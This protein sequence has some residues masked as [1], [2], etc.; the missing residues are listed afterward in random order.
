VRKQQLLIMK[1]FLLPLLAVSAYGGHAFLEDGKEYVYEAE[2]YQNA[3]TMDYSPSAAA[4]GWRFRVRMQVAG[5]KINFRVTDRSSSQYV[6]P[7]STTD[8]AW[9]KTTFTSGPSSGSNEFS[10]TYKNGQAVSIDVP[11]SFETHHRN[12]AR[13][14]ATSW[15][16]SLENKDYFLTQENLL[17]GDCKVQY[18]VSNNVI[19]KSVS[20]FRDCKHRKF[21]IVDNFRGYRCDGDWSME[22]WDYYGKENEGR[23]DPEP[24][25]SSTNTM[26]VVEKKGNRFQVNKMVVSGSVAAQYFESK[27]AS[28]FI[29]VNKTLTLADIR[30]SDGSIRPS[31]TIT[32]EDL[33]YEMSDDDYKWNKDR[34]LKAKE[35]F[36]SS[37]EYFKED[38]VTLQ[39]GIVKILDMI[40]ENFDIHDV[41]QPNMDKMHKFGAG[42]AMPILYAMNYNSL[43]DVF[44]Q[45]K[46]DTSE[47]GVAKQNM[48]REFVAEAGTSAA[49][50]FIKDAVMTNL[51]D[52]SSDAARAVTGI[53]FHIRRPN[54][55]LVNA[56]AEILESDRLGLVK[57]AGPLALAHLIQRT[58]Y[59]AGNPMSEDRRQCVRELSDTWAEKY[60][61]KFTETEDIQ[62][63]LM[64]ISFLTNLRSVKAKELLK[65][66][67]YG[68]YPGINDQIQSKAVKAAFWGT[69][70]TQSTIEFY[71][72]IFM[73]MQNGHGSR[74]AAI[75]QMFIMNSVDVTTLS[76]IMTQMFAEQDNE[77]LNYVF[78]LFEKYANSKYGCSEELK[79]DKVKYFLK[80]MRQM[81]IH[82]TEFGFGISKTYRMSFVQ[83]KYGYGGGYEFWVLGSHSSTTPLELGMRLDT[84]LFGGYQSNLL[85][86][87]IRIEGL[88][89]TLIRKFFMKMPENEWRI[90][91]L[92]NVFNSMNVALKPDQ[93][94]KVEFQVLL[95]DVVVLHKMFDEKAAEKGGELKEFMSSL[96]GTGNQYS[97]NHQRVLQWGSAIY[98]QPTESGLPM[99]YASALTS[100]V[101]LEATV[102][103]GLSR[104][105]I[106]RDIDYDLHANT[107]ATTIMTFFVP[108]RRVSYGIVHDRVY[109][110]HFPRHIIMGVNIVKKELRLQILRPTIDEP[111]MMVMH[112]R[113]SVMARGA[114]I[115]GEVDLSANCPSCPRKMIISKGSDALKSRSVIDYSSKHLGSHTKVEFF[116]CEMVEIEEA[117]TTGYTINAFMPYNKSPKTPFNVF[118]MGVRQIQAFFL[119]FPRTEQCGGYFRF[120]QSKENPVTEIDISIQGKMLDNNKDSQLGQVGKKTFVKIEVVA[121]G[122]KEAEKREFKLNMKIERGVGG[123]KNTLK[124]QFGAS[125]NQLIG[126]P[127]Y[128]ICGSMTNQYSPFGKSYMNTNLEE[129]LAV[130]G[131]GG[132]KYGEGT[133]CGAAQGSTDFKFE[134]STT[135]HGRE[136]L[137]DKWFYKKCMEQRSSSEWRTSEDPYT[138]ECWLTLW[139][140]SLA[141]KYTWSLDFEKTTPTVKGWL[142]K[143]QT[144]IKAGLIPYYD[145]D[146]D[147]LTGAITDTPKISFEFEFKNKDR[148]VDATFITD[149]G[150]SKFPNVNLNLPNW[151]GRL[152]QLKLETTIPGLIQSN[153]LSMLNF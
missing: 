71:L 100:L 95:K 147:A 145:V 152:R 120:S 90:Q 37:G 88:G 14:F 42:S 47:A 31:G 96:Q 4:V 44:K 64:A 82:N 56:F 76:M 83:D 65:P 22:A 46:G 110:A 131:S 124:V 35:P 3:G 86:L 61:K 142:S 151:T 54:V 117:K 32:L 51:F 34:D 30:D 69:I 130:T 138:A 5:D 7:W 89:K 114:N 101:S 15:Q 143:S 106:F 113:T 111:F 116:D 9:D 66:V 38:Q 62:E 1:L 20:H 140:A 11:S 41:S 107:Q 80:Y 78:T 103:R 136:E 129:R 72:P 6:G 141:R 98:E 85:T 52:K 94:V 109:T 74:I 133:K 99:A 105:V 121:K 137:K 104:G 97:I 33:S 108:S 59:L 119:Y 127:D 132:I 112:S 25:Y 50:I 150:T 91:D 39:G 126:L 73:N 60:F 148:A 149:K 123:L 29:H 63:R 27:G 21:R 93:P 81:G 84:N 67:A 19:S 43:M 12:M 122:Q 118:L 48:F 77:V 23:N 134:H 70:Y 75:D 79:A 45:L 68:E 53:A 49:A 36:F 146:P 2:T 102:K 55:Q 153:I 18:A 28:N 128:V 139:D 135:Q 26:F 57:M 10:I 115:G 8:W 58:C 87:N 125:G 17:H 16:I 144:I 92:Q 40:W 13:A 24:L